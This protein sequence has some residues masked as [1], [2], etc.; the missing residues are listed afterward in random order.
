MRTD[1]RKKSQ[2][3]TPNRKQL[4][5][6]WIQTLRDPEK[7]KNFEEAIRNSGVTLM[8]LRDIIEELERGILAK[9]ASEESYSKDWQFLQAHRNGALEMLKTMKKL[10]DH[11]E[12]DD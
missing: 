8:R 12:L 6:L 10:T 9:Q 3:G 1:P 7:K 2:P 5:T 11:V 4:N